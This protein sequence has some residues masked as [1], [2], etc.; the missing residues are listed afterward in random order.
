MTVRVPAD[1]A[2][3][4][5]L[6][7][8]LSARTGVALESYKPR[9]LRR[10]IAVRMR[11][12]GVHTF[13]DYRRLLA[14][15][16]AELERLQDALTINVTRFFR[17]PE[18]WDA[19]ARLMPALVQRGGEQRWWSAGCASGEE[20]YTLAMLWAEH[21]TGEDAL[22]RLRVDAT[23]IDRV[24]LNRARRGHYRDDAFVEAPPAVVARWTRPVEG[25]REVSPALRA[26]V[27]VRRLELTGAPLPT[28]AYD[29]IACRNVVIYFDRGM[30]ERLFDAFHAALRPGGHLVLGKVETLLG[31]ARERFEVVDVRERIYRRPA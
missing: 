4:L 18:V 10:R 26:V 25:G 21:A 1:E 11:A 28:A 31:P 15:S 22:G 6:A 30:Q 29:L 27:Q 12:C 16:A 3:F 5:A 2:A 7:R 13:D 23:D 9:C 8:D 19:V 14:G 24:S 20:A 17:N